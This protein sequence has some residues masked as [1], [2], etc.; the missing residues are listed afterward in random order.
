MRTYVIKTSVPATVTYTYIVEAETPEEAEE[1][2]FKLDS[3][4]CETETDLQ[5]EKIISVYLLEE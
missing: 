3:D 4:D 2:V 1:K 5:N